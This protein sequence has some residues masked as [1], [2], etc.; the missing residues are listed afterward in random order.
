MKPT[1]ARNQL[2]CNHLAQMTFAAISAVSCGMNPDIIGT[3]MKMNLR[4]TIRSLALALIVSSTVGCASTVSHHFSGQQMSTPGS[5]PGNLT[6]V[7]FSD[8]TIEGAQL[9][10]SFMH[11]GSEIIRF[12]YIDDTYVA[13]TIDGRAVVLDKNFLNYPDTVYAGET[14]EVSLKLPSHLNPAAITHI[15]ATLDNKR[16]IVQIQPSFRNLPLPSARVVARR[17]PSPAS[18]PLAEFAE[19]EKPKTLGGKIA[20]KVDTIYA[21]LKKTAVRSPRGKESPKLIAAPSL[22]PPDP[23]LTGTVPVTVE[24]SQEIG[25]LLHAVISWNSGET[26]QRL[27][28]GESQTFHLEPGRHELSFEC[29]QTPLAST[30]GRLP[31]T[32]RPGRPIRIKLKARARYYGTDVTARLWYRGKLVLEKE[33]APG[34]RL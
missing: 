17:S 5:A 18:L 23:L 19:P 3:A 26:V 16:R 20:K 30:V 28:A 15:I 7:G 6:V 10:L 2:F 33:F 4:S 1:L 31:V 8:S 21:S 14:A 9:H 25:G 11:R 22:I 13:G 24:F 32:A 34:G 27:A 29:A 12:S